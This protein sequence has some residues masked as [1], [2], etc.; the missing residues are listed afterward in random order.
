MTQD[1]M[2]MCIGIYLELARSPDRKITN[3]TFQRLLN[4][5]IVSKPTNNAIAALSPSPISTV[6]F[7]KNSDKAIKE[8]VITEC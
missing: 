2:D 8:R 6:D 4:V 3:E 1:S 5:D 7:A